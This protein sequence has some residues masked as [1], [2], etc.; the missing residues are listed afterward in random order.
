MCSLN[1]SIHISRTSWIIHN[2]L[3]VSRTIY[4]RSRWRSRLRGSSIHTRHYSRWWW[5][6]DSISGNK[7]LM[8]SKSEEIQQGA[9]LSCSAHVWSSSSHEPFSPLQLSLTDR[10]V[11]QSIRNLILHWELVLNIFQSLQIQ[12]LSTITANAN[13]KI[14]CGGARWNLHLA[15]FVQIWRAPHFIFADRVR[16]LLSARI[17]SGTIERSPQSRSQ[18]TV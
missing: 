7:I 6:L 8:G 4:L 1:S 9:R 11:L 2:I 17:V 16:S 10:I 13:W 3:S 14:L 18:T 15:E 12:K 5:R